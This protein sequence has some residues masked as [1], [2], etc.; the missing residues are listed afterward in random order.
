M[1]DHMVEKYPGAV[2][3]RVGK[4][5]II[6]Q[7]QPG[8]D[9]KPG[10]S[11]K[12]LGKRKADVLDEPPPPLRQPPPAPPNDEKLALATQLI[13]LLDMRQSTFDGQMVDT[14]Q[15]LAALGK[16]IVQ[17]TKKLNEVLLRPAGMRLRAIREMQAS[18]YSDVKQM[19]D[20][21]VG[22]LES[23][24]AYNKRAQDEIVRVLETL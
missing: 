24:E 5:I 2:K 6:E 13:Q 15:Q 16:S 12:A 21:A 10:P 11:G 20:S 1:K 18:I 19:E 7:P 8:G 17:Q 22:L 3:R 14:Q 9:G 23:Y 4:T